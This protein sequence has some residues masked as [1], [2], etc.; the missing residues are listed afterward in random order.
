VVINEELNNLSPPDTFRVNRLWNMSWAG[1]VAFMGGKRNLYRMFVR[2]PEGN[3]HLEEAD[4]D[5]G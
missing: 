3:D 2:K 4:V 5:W 1:H